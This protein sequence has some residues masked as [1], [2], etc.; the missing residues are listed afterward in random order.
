MWVGAPVPLLP[1]P[2]IEEHGKESWANLFIFNAGSR[3]SCGTEPGYG[4]LK[5]VE[6]SNTQAPCCQMVGQ[7]K[8]EA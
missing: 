6:K 5:R 1:Q 7:K 4:R 2:P 8:R 3:Y